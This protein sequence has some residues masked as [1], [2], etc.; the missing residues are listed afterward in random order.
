MKQHNNTDGRTPRYPLS[1][2]LER[3]ADAVVFGGKLIMR[4]GITLVPEQLDRDVLSGCGSTLRGTV[5]DTVYRLSRLG[6]R[7]PGL[8]EVILSSAEYLVAAAGPEAQQELN[9]RI[10]TIRQELLNPHKH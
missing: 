10:N 6:Q 5:D 1:L 8:S 3:K 4:Q 9:T 2:P 7:S